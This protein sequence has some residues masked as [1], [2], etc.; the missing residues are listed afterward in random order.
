[1]FARRLFV[2]CLALVLIARTVHCLYVDVSL[3]ASAAGESNGNRPLSDPNES[4]P[5]ESGCLCKG[6]LVIVPS[7]P[8][9]LERQSESLAAADLMLAPSA[10]GLDLQLAAQ[11]T[12][13]DLSWPPPRSGRMVRAL[14]ASWQI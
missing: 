4:D 3:C 7:L 5:N 11:A 1:M 8:A 13:Q 9:D 14:I 6:A 2:G 12:P 10:L